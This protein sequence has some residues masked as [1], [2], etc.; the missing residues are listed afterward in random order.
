MVYRLLLALLL[1]SPAS[2][3]DWGDTYFCTMT[4]Y[5]YVTNEGKQTHWPLENFKFH[6]D[7]DKKALVFGDSGRYFAE[8][9]L[10]VELF[11][12]EQVSFD[13]K[14]DSSHFKLRGSKAIYTAM[15]GPQ[16]TIIA[17][18]CDKF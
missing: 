7:S 9:E 5:S 17:A 6:M 4:H 1:I 16:A 8:L 13:A 18:D 12:P 11:Y 15:Y 2:F 3:A 10:P 14:N